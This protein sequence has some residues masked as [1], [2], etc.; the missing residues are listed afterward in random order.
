MTKCERCGTDVVETTSTIV[1]D[2]RF[3]H[4]Y[5]KDIQLCILCRS[6]WE[7]VNTEWLKK[8]SVHIRREEEREEIPWVLQIAAKIEDEPPMSWCEMHGLK[9]LKKDN[10]GGGFVPEIHLGAKAAYRIE[11][12]K[13]MIGAY[14][15][16]S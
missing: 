13:A 7:E 5:I 15:K 4:N 6:S 3:G 9:I 2:D 12:A 8:T 16:S 11:L 10:E 14:E 1:P